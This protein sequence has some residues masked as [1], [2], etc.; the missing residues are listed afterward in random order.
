MFDL[1]TGKTVHIP[2]RPALPI[3]LT[4]A[5]EAIVIL[6]AVVLP[7]LYVT[8]SVPRIP[9][10]MAFVVAAPA[11]PPPP[12][13]PAPAAQAAKAAPTKAPVNPAAA[14]V[15]APRTIEPDAVVASNE[16]VPGGVEGG[17]P[18]GVPGGVVGGV[19]NEA[20]PPPPP[21]PP[22][23]AAPRGPVRIGGQLQAPA[24]LKRVE[25]I[26][27]PLA[28]HA[29]LSGV[30]ILEAT[31][32]EEG[33]VVTATVL[34]SAGGILDQE[35]LAAVKQWRYSPLVLNGRKESFVLTVTLSFN[36]TQFTG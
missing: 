20:P 12:P 27:P 23:P 19:V 32:N 35:A 34:R 11:P 14:P 16:G 24:L 36:L 21:P 15:D 8:D 13:P 1:V 22:P 6:L 18:G 17:I 3:V 33:Q 4:S 10:M 2:Q 28:V 26:Y 25:P 7:I 30:V 9:T 31:V 29:H 5:L